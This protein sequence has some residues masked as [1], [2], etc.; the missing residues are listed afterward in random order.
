M[1]TEGYFREIAKILDLR[2]NDTFVCYDSG[3]VHPSARLAWMLRSYGAKNVYVL[4]GTIDAWI[5]E[6]YEVGKPK[7]KI[8]KRKK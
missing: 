2:I 7:S 1:Q 4:N 5:K 8:F 3:T 6:G